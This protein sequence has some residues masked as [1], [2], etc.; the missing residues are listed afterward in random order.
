MTIRDRIKDFRRVPASE[1]SARHRRRDGAVVANDNQ[2]PEELTTFL[3]SVF[4][5]LPLVKGGAF[6]ICAPAGDRYISFLQACGDCSLQVRQGLCWAKQQM[7]FGRQDYHYQH[8][9]IIYGWMAGA[10]HYFVDDRT[11]TS[12]WQ[13]D[14]PHT[15]A[16]HPTM[17]PVE[18]PS[19]AI[20]NSSQRGEYIY[21][22][23]LGSGTTLIAAEQ[24]GRICYGM[25]I[26][27]KYVAVILQRAKD[28]GLTPRLT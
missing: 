28:I 16:E 3:S 20:V 1:L 21:D 14:R 22:P 23:F 13:V 11:Q 8:E 24:L 4:S 26:E 5:I 7:V 19:K 17:K 6:Y 27:P 12:V 18:L 2:T 9:L 10:S 15:S 25:E